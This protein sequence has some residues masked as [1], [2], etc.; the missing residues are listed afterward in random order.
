MRALVFAALAFALVSVVLFSSGPADAQDADY[1][2]TVA[3]LETRVAELEGTVEARGD[4]INAQR[5]QIAELKAGEREAARDPRCTDV[6]PAVAEAMLTGLEDGGGMSLVAIQSVKSAD[7]E[8]VYFVAG[9]LLGP[10]MG[11]GEIVVL[12]T[13]KIDDIGI[14]MAVNEMAQSFFVWPDADSTDANMTM[15]DDGAK[16]AESCTKALLKK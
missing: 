16:A 7:F 11:D 2:A 6:A 14:I 13:N 10:G 3:A 12:A 15:D 5:T 1:P 4:K 9:N 8:N